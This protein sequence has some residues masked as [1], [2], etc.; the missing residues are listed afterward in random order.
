MLHYAIIFF[1]LALIAA[2]FGWGTVSAALALI[3]KILFLIFIVMSVAMF[4]WAWKKG[5]F[6][7][8]VTRDPK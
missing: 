1:V 3:G 5:L 2:L 4:L 7:I 6:K 8:A